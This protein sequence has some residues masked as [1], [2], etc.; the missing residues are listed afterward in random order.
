MV[1]L[2]KYRMYRYIIKLR[3]LNE[4][5]PIT[6][7]GEPLNFLIRVSPVIRSW[8]K[9]SESYTFRHLRT[10]DDYPILMYLALK[11]EFAIKQSNSKIILNTSTG[12]TKENLLGFFDYYKIDIPEFIKEI[13]RSY[14]KEYKIPKRYERK[15][16]APNHININYI[17][18]NN[19]ATS[20]LKG[21]MN[22]KRNLEANTE[23]VNSSRAPGLQLFNFLNTRTTRKKSKPVT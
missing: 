20:R 15:G 22:A 4:L 16:N 19:N 9:N 8:V 1:S 12:I 6:I 17:G 5:K 23:N 10:P 18:N 11:R 2:K 13:K 21:S 3:N 7:E 14:T